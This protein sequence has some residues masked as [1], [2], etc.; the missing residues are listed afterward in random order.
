M[1]AL[2]PLAVAFGFLSCLPVGN[3]RVEEVELGRSL[4]WFPALRGAR[5]RGM[6]VHW[7]FLHSIPGETADAYQRMQEAIPHLVHLQPPNTVTPVEFHRFSPYYDQ[8]HV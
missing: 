6:Y 2:R 5:E 1:K 7:I 8:G 3:G 4:G